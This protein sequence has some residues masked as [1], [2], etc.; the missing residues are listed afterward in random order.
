MDLIGVLATVLGC[1]LVLLL[2]FA[3]SFAASRK[4]T[5]WAFKNCFGFLPTRKHADKILFEK[6]KKLVLNR[7][8]LSQRN[9]QVLLH[10]IKVGESKMYP[11][12]RDG[13]NASCK[14]L[15]QAKTLA[16]EFGYID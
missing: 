10:D 12:T 6:E 7:L 11:K 8:E 14:D 16:R 1:V 2:A 3:A 13:Y 4:D 9:I 15:K 5:I